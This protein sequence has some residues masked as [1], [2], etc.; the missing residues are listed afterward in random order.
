MLLFVTSLAGQTA[1]EYITSQHT[2]VFGELITPGYPQSYPN[3]L[4]RIWNISAPTGYQVRLYF[5][6]FD[7][8]YSAYCEYDYVKVG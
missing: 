2:S 7:V 5:T 8:E 6:V 4:T 3:D 1:G